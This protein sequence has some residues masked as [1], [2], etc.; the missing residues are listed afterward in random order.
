MQSPSLD[1]FEVFLVVAEAG[2][3]TSAAKQLKRSKSAIS[4]LI[5]NLESELSFPLF[6]RTTRQF[7]LTE[8]GKQLYTQCLSLKR[9][10]DS[11]RYLLQGM[12][13]Q[14]K[15]RLVVACNGYLAADALAAPIHTYLKNYPEVDLELIADERMPNFEKESIDIDYDWQFKMCE[16][17]YKGGFS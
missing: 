1:H 2:S 9:E 4:Q 12:H 6:K 8:A 16:I 10:L 5:R 14:P 7:T 11:T 17:L 13:E 3:I 15:G